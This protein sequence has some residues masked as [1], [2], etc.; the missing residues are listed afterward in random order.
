MDDD[1][2]MLWAR[3]VK[4]DSAGRQWGEVWE[5]MEA[6]SAQLVPRLV[7]ILCVTDTDKLEGMTVPGSPEGGDMQSIFT[8]VRLLDAIDTSQLSNL[9]SDASSSAVEVVKQLALVLGLT[10]KDILAA[11]GITKG[12]FGN[13]QRNHATP[14]RLDRHPGLWSLAQSVEVIAERAP[15]NDVQ[16]WLSADRVEMLREGHHRELVALATTPVT[17]APEA[18]SE[19]RP[20]AVGYFDEDSETLAG[21]V[22][23]NPPAHPTTVQG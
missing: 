12:V 8:V 1:E 3:Q 19:E 15:D 16:S 6:V 20:M 9:A 18:R 7:D 17:R 13:W 11:A 2:V 23:G 14:V 21:A 22:A 4:R 10:Q 5:I